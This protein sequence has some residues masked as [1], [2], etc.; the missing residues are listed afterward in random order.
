MRYFFA[1]AKILPDPDYIVEDVIAAAELALRETFDFKTRDFA[2]HVFASQ[3]LSLLQSVEGVEAALLDRL[4]TGA[5]LQRNEVLIADPATATVGGEI[6]LLHPQP[7]DHLE[8]I[9]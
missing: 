5:L 4:Y 7:L 1:A 3:I 6:L 9:A 2:Q 8:I